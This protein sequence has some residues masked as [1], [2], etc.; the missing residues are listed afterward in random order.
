MKKLLVLSVLLGLMALPVFADHVS[1]DFGGD[2]TFGFIGD[3]GDNENE[4]IDLT[5]DVIVGIDDY[6]SLTWSQKNLEAAGGV[7]LDKALGTTDVGMWLDLPV[8][9]KV[10]WG[11]DDPDANE[12]HDITGYGNEAV[13]NFSPDEYWG[14]AFMV[15]YSIVEVELAFNPT[16]DPLGDVIGGPQAGVGYLLAGLALKEPIPGLNAEVYYFQNKSA[17]DAFDLGQIGVDAAYAMEISGIG[18]EAG[19]G[20]L[21]DMDD[22]AANA[23][24]FGIGLVASVSMFE[25]SLGVDGN[26]TDALDDL[27]ATVEVAPV[28]LA[29]I[30][31]GFWYDAAGSDLMEVD[32]GVNAHIGAVEAYLGYLVTDVGAGD[33]YNSPAG[34]IDGGAYLKF[35]V[36]Y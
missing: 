34:I 7:E 9:F 17:Y 19:L 29:T 11:Y 4:K 6:N 12:F 14:V 32:L 8:G 2:H 27:T 22:A 36:N 30:Y 33:N 15:S 5:F 23:W 16:S 25:I 10:M 35:D 24:A 31:A 28:D 13:F 18:L 21:Y 20:F 1:V 26:E 3:F